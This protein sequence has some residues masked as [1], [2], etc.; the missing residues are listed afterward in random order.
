MKE[1]QSVILKEIPNF[2]S[3][4]IPIWEYF[5]KIVKFIFYK[6]WKRNVFDEKKQ[7]FI[8]DK[9]SG[10]VENIF[11]ILSDKLQGKSYS[12]RDCQLQI[13][14]EIQENKIA[15]NTGKNQSAT[16]LLELYGNDILRLAYSYLQNMQDSE[17]ILQETLIR[18]IQ[19]APDLHNTSQQK[20]WLFR[21]A[22]NLC[23]DKLRYK[24][25]HA[26]DE[27]KETLVEEKRA[28]LSFVWEAVKSLPVKY[29]EAI[30]LFYYEGYSIKE[31]SNIL[32]RKE[33]TIRSDLRRGREKLKNILKEEYDFE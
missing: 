13:E 3:A 17:D 30:H 20:A 18:Y 23:K 1:G 15:E 21:V 24:K 27:L 32:K 8:S 10:K 11:Q 29:R 5:L 7:Y 33:S 19:K 4:D 2:Y 16:E 14:N 31:I 9:I 12:Q 22:V 28:D 26:S 6:F 25:S